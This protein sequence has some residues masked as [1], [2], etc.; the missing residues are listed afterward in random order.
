MGTVT[1]KRT[2]A[3]L[4]LLRVAVATVFTVHGY[5]KIL[6]GH[7]DRT[8]ALF[9]T[10][11]IPAPE[12]SAWVIGALELGGGVL[13]AVGFWARPIALLLAIEMAVVIVRVR[14][15]QGFL[16]AAEFELVLLAACLALTATGAGRFS[17]EGSSR[18]RPAR[19]RRGRT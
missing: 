5:V 9:M 11:N 16:G 14:W 17:L 8:V 12:I 3:G 10:V 2:D 1:A 4:L 15:A 6:G 18:A 13:L 7:F 19:N